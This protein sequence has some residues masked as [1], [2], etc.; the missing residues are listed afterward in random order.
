[1][2]D[3]I[4]LLGYMGSGKSALGELLSKQL[5]T[6]HLDLDSVIENA[7]G[8]SIS[9]G[10]KQHGELAFRKLER[11]QLHQ[12]SEPSI[13]SVGGGTPCFYDNMDQMN[14]MGTTIWLDAS[15]EVLAKRLSDARAKGK[16]RPLIRGVEDADLP[17]F[18]RKHLFERQ[19]YYSQAQWTVNAELSVADLAQEVLNQ[20]K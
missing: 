9:D 8:M 4:F 10:M 15:P 13:I 18:V 2:S 14:Q 11:E 3:M 19:V 16:D 20:I 1:M 12:L 17:D 6:K 5:N 7:W